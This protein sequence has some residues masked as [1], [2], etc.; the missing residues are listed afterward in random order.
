M[1]PTEGA[2]GGSGDELRSETA[3]M[4]RFLIALLALG[5]AFAPLA[6][7]ANPVVV[8]K[9]SAGDIKI[10]LLED[11]APETVKNFLK[12]VDD[13][14][15]DNTIFHRVISNFMIQGGGFTKELNK[16]TTP[17]GIREA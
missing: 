10:E 15:Y 11:K 16:A 13:K 9:T 3:A 7:A 5:F 2:R 8:M 12:Y 17:E 4:K 1:I 14:H 6:R